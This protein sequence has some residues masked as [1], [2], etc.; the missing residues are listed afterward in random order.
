MRSS[1]LRR[2]LF[3]VALVCASMRHVECYTPHQ[4]LERRDVWKGLVSG[5]VATT[6]VMTLDNQEAHAVISSKYCAYGE[7][8]GCDDLAEGN[9][10]IKEL[11]Q[12]SAAKKE[13]IQKV[14]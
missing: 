3:L 8:D 14:R 11:Q 9:A 13:V 5:M 6:T 10:Y 7:G 1:T 12:R 4:P 2:V